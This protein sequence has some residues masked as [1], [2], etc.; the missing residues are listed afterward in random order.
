[1]DLLKATAHSG[2]SFSLLWLVCVSK[3]LIPRGCCCFCCWP[4][5]SWDS[6]FFK[7]MGSRWS[8][9]IRVT[10]GWPLLDKDSLHQ[11]SSVIIRC[12]YA[13]GLFV[14]FVGFSVE[15]HAFKLDL[16]N[17]YFYICMVKTLH[18]QSAFLNFLFIC[19]NNFK[20]KYCSEDFSLADPSACFLIIQ[21]VHADVSEK[22]LFVCFPP[23]SNLG[24]S[25]VGWNCF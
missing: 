13:M 4:M 23:G 25:L 12:F 2:C 7:G 3:L 10:F 22:C 20:V 9:E 11:L 6:F 17:W 21:H 15:H 8:D 1:M 14:P 19:F 18:A 5:G 16:R 24:L